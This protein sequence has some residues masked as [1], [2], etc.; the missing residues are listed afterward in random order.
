MDVSSMRFNTVQAPDHD[1]WEGTRSLLFPQ[2]IPVEYKLISDM[3][4]VVDM[5]RNGMRYYGEAHHDG[6]AG[7]ESITSDYSVDIY[8]GQFHKSYNING[9]LYFSS[10]TLLKRCSGLAAVAREFLEVPTYRKIKDLLIVARESDYFNRQSDAKMGI[11]L[12]VEVSLNSQNLQA[13]SSAVRVTYNQI[14]I[15]DNTVFDLVPY[16]RSKDWVLP[17][18]CLMVWNDNLFESLYISEQGVVTKRDSRVSPLLHDPF[19]EVTKEERD[20]IRMLYPEGEFI[21]DTFP[22]H[23]RMLSQENIH[24]LSRRINFTPLHYTEKERR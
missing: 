7:V 2:G 18:P 12:I 20:L 10:G 4:C 5:T 23:I 24:E 9:T 22:K 16:M 15:D 8:H 17:L 11:H 6:T 19:G 3:L 13:A 21:L 1:S 14:N